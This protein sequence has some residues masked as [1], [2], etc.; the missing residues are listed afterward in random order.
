M[1]GRNDKCVSMQSNLNTNNLNAS[2]LNVNWILPPEVDVNALQIAAAHQSPILAKMLVRRGITTPDAMTAFLAPLHTPEV[3][4]LDL[5][6]MDLAL[7]RLETALAE[8]QPILIYGDFDVDGITG[9]AVLMETLTYLKAKVSYYIPDRAKEGHGLHSASLCRL[10][11]TRQLKLVISTDTGITNYNEVCMLSNL[12]VDTIITDHHELAEMLPPSV[13][14]INPRM[15]DNQQHPLAPMAGVGVAFKLCELLLARHNAPAEIT[16]KLLDLVAIGTIADVAALTLE[17]RRLVQQGVTVMNTRQ[18]TG[19]VAILEQAG[20]LPEAELSAETVG[21]VLGPR[22]NAIGRLENAND[23]VTLLTTQDATEAARLASHLEALNRRRKDLCDKTTLEAEQFIRQAGVSVGVNDN[24]QRALVL[25]SPDWNLGVIG[26][27]ANRL[28]DRYRVPVFM[29]VHDTQANTFRCS[30]RSIEGFPLVEVLEPLKD[31]FTVFG[32]HAMAGG[33]TLPVERFHRC[34]QA[35]YDIAAAR[36]TPEMMQKPLKIDVCLDLSEATTTFIDHLAV[37]EPTGQANRPPVVALQKLTVA[38]SRL[39]NEQH[40]KLVLSDPNHPKAPALEAIYWRLGDRSVPQ[41]GDE[42]DVAGQLTLN[43][44]NGSERPQLILADFRPAGRTQLRTPP[45]VSSR[46]SGF[47]PVAPVLA[48]TLPSAL[49]S[50]LPSDMTAD[51]TPATAAVAGKATVKVGVSP[52]VLAQAINAPVKPAIK[53]AMTLPAD[54]TT[55]A[56]DKSPMWVDHRHRSDL[57]QYIGLLLQDSTPQRLVYHEGR[58]PNLPYL[59]PHH[60]ISRLQAQPAEELIFWDLPPDADTLQQVL[61]TV[62]PKVVHWAAGKFATVPLRPA[63]TDFLKVLLYVLNQSQANEAIKVTALASQLATTESVILCGLNVLQQCAYIQTT[64]PPPTDTT[65]GELTVTVKLMPRNGQPAPGSFPL[66][67]AC[68][69]YA[70]AQVALYRE[71]LMGTQGNPA[72]SAAAIPL[73][74]TK[75]PALA[76]R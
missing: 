60:C 2:N 18:R 25:A 40:L 59:Q 20:V 27:V 32:G 4:G 9:T 73:P 30:A 76:E 58:S 71:S 29:M 52:P 61:A 28:V 50:D 5:P 13:A 63:P 56:A 7:E 36:I 22:L 54:A 33:F 34:R 1:Q 47:M 62:Q 26:I 57:E 35:L 6:G 31:M 41:T 21:F 46:Q 67:M 39:L 51:S 42:V 24:E 68:L 49:P 43:R 69:A 37:L 55:D 10:V 3:S 74:I 53:P 72:M 17:N 12:G 38:A 16:T 23:A 66:A 19:L 8:Q 48:S 14:N 75:Q 65:V 44:F 45:A 64:M 15:L 70:M 11:S